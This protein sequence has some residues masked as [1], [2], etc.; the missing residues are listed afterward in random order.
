MFTI[1]QLMHIDR[2]DKITVSSETA[3]LACPISSFGLVFM[4]T[5][6][7][8]ARCSSFGASEARDVSL[9][10]FVGEII[11]VFAILP[12]G[13]AAVVMAATIPGTHPM[14]IADEERSD[15]VGDTKGDDVPGGFMTLITNAT[16]V[17][18]A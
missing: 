11:D 9:F 13:H 16:F 14:R 4:P 1:S 15:L 6:R 2:T 5:A 17:S 18:C 10:G 7:T 12:Q 8:L 3:D